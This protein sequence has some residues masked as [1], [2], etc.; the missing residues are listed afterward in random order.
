MGNNFIATISVLSLA[1]LVIAANSIFTANIT[2]PQFDNIPAVN[3]QE[4]T[5]V[6]NVSMT[7]EQAI[8]S[9]IEKI[10]EKYGVNATGMTP[11]AVLCQTDD[12]GED[13]W[14]ISFFPAE[15]EGVLYGDE[16]ELQNSDSLIPIEGGHDPMPS[17]SGGADKKNDV[18]YVYINLK[19]GEARYISREKL[20]ETISDEELDSM[21]FQNRNK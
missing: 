6:I 14:Y 2:T 15:M 16:E 10:K 4:M 11:I 18:F 20:G 3:T 5:T 13:Y 7:K 1:A 21:E 19:T 12:T 17:I 9:A 8:E